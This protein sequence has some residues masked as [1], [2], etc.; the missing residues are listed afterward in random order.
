MS[1]EAMLKLPNT[2]EPIEAD[3]FRAFFEIHVGDGSPAAAFGAFPIGV[4]PSWSF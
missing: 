2:A 4:S 1:L 3:R